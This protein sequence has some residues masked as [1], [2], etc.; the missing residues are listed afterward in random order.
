M[1]VRHLTMRTGRPRTCHACGAVPERR[2]SP[3]PS[4]PSPLPRLRR[5]PAAASSSPPSDAHSAPPAVIAGARQAHRHPGGPSRPSSPSSEAHHRSD[6]LSAG[7]GVPLRPGARSR[8]PPACP[9]PTSCPRA[10]LSRA[11]STANGTPSPCSI[12][13][14]TPARRVSR[15]A[16]TTAR[17]ADHGCSRCRSGRGPGRGGVVGAGGGEPAQES[18]VRFGR[19]GRRA[20]RRAPVGLAAGWPR[21]ECAGAPRGAAS[22]R[23][24]RRPRPTHW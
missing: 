13:P 2:R 9:S 8:L 11:T 14:A 1:G 6:R 24:P 7:S 17:C 19:A 16:S 3:A 21:D 18:E 10:P 5:N 12:P 4:P 22:G 23:A 15:L 20:G